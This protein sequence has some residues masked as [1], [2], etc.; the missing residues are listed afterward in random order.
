M[1]FTPATFLLSAAIPLFATPLAAMAQEA[2][3][4]PL[5]QD[6]TRDPTPQSG[7]QS[8]PQEPGSDDLHSIY[9]TAAGVDRLD[10]VAGSSVVTGVALQR[11]SSGQIGEVLASLPGVSAT[12]FAPG[13]SRP[14]LRGFGGE[15]VR[16]LSDGTGS[17]DASSTSADHAVA[18]DPLI[19][20]R[21]EVLRGPAVLLYGS[22]AIGG[23]VNVITKRIPPRLPDEAVHVDALAGMDTASDLREVGASID[24]PIGG[25]FAVH[26]D[27]S[28]RVTNDLEI[29]GFVASPFLR[30]DLLADADEEEEEGHLEEAAEL[31]EAANARGVLPNSFTEATSAGAGVAWFSGASNIGA[32]FGYYDTTYGIPGLPGIGH[33]HHDEGE[34]VIDGEEEDHGEEHGEENVSIG[35]R[36]YRAD[37][38][39]ELDLGSGFFDSVQTRL[40]WSDYTH[41]EF[42]GE[43]TGT[44][45][46]VEGVEGRVELVQSR[47]ALGAGGWRGSTGV[48]YSHV[49][50]Q[51]LGEEAFVPPNV[52]ESFA[53]FGLQEFD[54]DA[55]EI[56]VGA[57]YENTSIDAETFGLG[58]VSRDFGTFSAAVGAGYTLFDDFRVGLN[59]S[60]TERAPSAQ[61]LFADGPHLATQ[62]FEIGNPGLATESSWGGE[63]YLRGSVG[64]VQVNATLYRNWFD[65]FI[66]LSATGEEEDGLAVFA[67]LQQDADQWGFEAQATFPIIETGGFELLGDLRADYTRATLD[68]GE[69]VPR[70]PPLSLYG[71]LE[72]RLDHVDLRGEVEWHDEQD[73]VAPLEAPTDGYTMVN[74]SIAWHP[75]EG[76]DN[77]VVMAQVNNILDEDAR[78]AASFTKDFVPLAGRN[79]R[80]SVRTSF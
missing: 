7:D 16:V 10:I 6:D 51:A 37:L 9:V 71:A 50:F 25:G 28:H 62:Q 63:A 47:R 12:S 39:G 11:E 23:A 69:P 68:S 59:A 27:G 74:A 57:R 48:Q 78:R 49:D 75:L 34:D 65:D 26:V 29:P 76:N 38:R 60:R 80:L 14:V 73:R 2:S 40:G 79:F 56:E 1:K 70:I 35:L 41:T 30:A 42:E 72:A 53:V 36:Q 45:F 20:D 3:P 46:D 77:I 19:A 52:T 21:V 58:D 22:Q 61:E 44:V 31:R 17:L 8:G 32:S 66:Y 24:A 55:L 13:A 64:P 67:F 18:V 15:R 4:A 33:V 54:F 43:E 5:A